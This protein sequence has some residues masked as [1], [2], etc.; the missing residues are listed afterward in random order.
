MPSAAS[1]L[2]AKYAKRIFAVI[3]APSIEAL[4]QA[5]LNTKN[6]LFETRQNKI[7]NQDFVN[8]PADSKINVLSGFAGL[9]VGEKQAINLYNQGFTPATYAVDVLGYSP[10]AASKINK[11]FPATSGTRKDVQTAEGA[12]AEE[13]Y[14]APLVNA[15]IEPYSQTL[16]GRSPKQISEGFS[17]KPE[18]ME[19][20]AKFLAGR[21]L[22][23]EIA[24]IRSRMTGGSSAHEALRDIQRAALNDIKVFQSQVSPETYKKAQE[25]ISEWIS[26]ATKSRIN[27]VKGQNQEFSNNIKQSQ[28]NQN[29]GGIDVSAVLRAIAE[30]NR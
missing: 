28:Q 12:L 15:A 25:Y 2:N 20:Q 16:F 18:D 29:Q 11:Q 24:G 26:G 14:L 19:R 27:A 30:K 7:Q 17:K 1:A 5:D 8:L 23:P 13:E 21:A 3:P 9:D 22:Q 4:F 6:S 10:E